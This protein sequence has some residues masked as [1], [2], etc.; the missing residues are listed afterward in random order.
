MSLS[1]IVNGKDFNFFKRVTITSA[2]FS[3]D[4]DI[5]INISGQEGFTMHNEGTGVV[6]YSFNGTTVH[7]DMDSTQDS[8]TLKFDHRR[9]SKIW[10]RI[11]SGSNIPVRF[12]AWAAK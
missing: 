5:V 10:F 8:K 11:K 1:A 2:T 7:G 4:C 9:V 6:E 12:E 3:S